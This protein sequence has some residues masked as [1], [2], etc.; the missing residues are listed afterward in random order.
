MFSLEQMSAIMH[1]LPA[2][3]FI[4]TRSGK[5]TAVFG[6]SDSRYYHDG[7]GLVGAYLHDVIKEPKAD[8]FLSEIAKALDHKELR[9]IEYGL[10]DD[11]LKGL[12]SDGSQ[13]EV[14]F[15]GRIKA[16]E[17]KI[18][19]ED[20]VLWMATNISCRHALEQKLISQSKTDELTGLWNR[21]HFEE[22]SAQELKRALRYQH[23][24]SL[25]ILDIDNFK[26]VNDTQG[27]KGGDAVLSGLASMMT[28]YMRES[29]V[30][31]RWGG[32]EFT[33]LMPCT[34]FDVAIEAAERL[35]KSVEQH[36]FEDD[37]CVTISIGVAQWQ[38]ES[39]SI[40]NLVSRA[41][42]ALYIAKRNGRNRIESVPN[43]AYLMKSNNQ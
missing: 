41:D 32:E 9:V 36:R 5:Y 18:E 11:D 31:T 35:R 28:E 12:N 14:W 2:P 30:I 20:A 37:I 25:L 15:E 42:Q 19:N 26:L 8:W 33:V 34:E 7:S 3:A 6:G 29:D 21:R 39:E 22:V 4:L 16:L 24:I 40:E 1:C 10:A 23:G 27:H 38:I 17:F 43:L 13:E